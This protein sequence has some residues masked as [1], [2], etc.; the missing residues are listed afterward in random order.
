[1]IPFSRYLSEQIA[2]HGTSQHFKFLR[3]IIDSYRPLDNALGIHFA[4]RPEIA[5]KFAGIYGTT[6]RAKLPIENFLDL[7]DKRAFYAEHIGKAILNKG[8]T[9]DPRHLLTTTDIMGDRDPLITSKTVINHPRLIPTYVDNNYRHIM[10]VLQHNHRLK[11]NVAKAAREAWQNEGIHGV[12]YW[13]NHPYDTD[14][15]PSDIDK[16]CHIVFSPRHI[17]YTGNY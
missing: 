1:M 7:R 6:Y 4:N 15:L 16:T 11:I 17:Q 8:F 5:N 9:A 12:T 3:R 2:Y 14:G 10:G 13:N